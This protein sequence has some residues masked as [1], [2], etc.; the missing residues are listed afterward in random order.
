VVVDGQQVGPSQPVWELHRR[1]F[2]D[3]SSKQH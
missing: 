1:A 2:G 3:Y